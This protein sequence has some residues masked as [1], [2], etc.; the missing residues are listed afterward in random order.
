MATD[1][2]KPLSKMTDKERSIAIDELQIQMHPLLVQVVETLDSDNFWWFYNE[3][4]TLDV[5]DH[6][7]DTEQRK[8]IKALRRALLLQFKA[9]YEE[10]FVERKI[11]L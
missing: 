5:E 7:E 11:E 3:Y 9:R 8:T 1:K 4:L 2:N 6:P 10:E